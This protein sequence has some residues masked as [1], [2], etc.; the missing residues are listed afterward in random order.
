MKAEALESKRAI[1]SGRERWLR[2]IECAVAFVCL[3]ACATSSEFYVVSSTVQ[4]T[5]P[6]TQDEVVSPIARPAKSAPSV[7][8]ATKVEAASRDGAPSDDACEVRMFLE[9][10]PGRGVSDGEI[11]A[12]IAEQV[13]DG[14]LINGHCI[15]RPGQSLQ[16]PAAML[17]AAP[18]GRPTLERFCRSD[19]DEKDYQFALSVLADEKAEGSQKSSAA[20]RPVK[21]C[22][23]NGIFH[24]A[25]PFTLTLL[26]KKGQS[27]GQYVD[28]LRVYRNGDLVGAWNR[29]SDRET[30]SK[31]ALSGDSL[32]AGIFA[33][34]Q[35]PHL[36]DMDIRVI[37]R[38][39][40][41][42][43]EVDTAVVDAHARFRARLSV[44]V[45]AVRG[46]VLSPS[47][48]QSLE[49]LRESLRL[50]VRRIERVVSDQVVVPSDAPCDTLTKGQPELQALSTEYRDAKK[51]GLADLEKLRAEAYARIDELKRIVIEKLPEQQQLL[52]EKMLVMAFH[53]TKESLND[54]QR[55]AVVACKAELVDRDPRANCGKAILEASPTLEGEYG[56]LTGV[57]RVI[58]GDLTFL[59]QTVDEAM[60]LADRL[61]DK[62]K[63]IGSDPNRQAQVFNAFAQSLA[64]QG[65]VFEPRRDNPPLLVGEQKL[66]LKYADKFQFFTL[67]PWNGVPIRV[68]GSTGADFT[69]AIAIPLVDILGGRYQWGVSRFAELRG[70]FGLGYVQTEEPNSD[71]KRSA[72]LPNLSLGVGTFRVGV[73]VAVGKGFGSTGERVRLIAGV[74]LFKLLS[75]SNV[76]A[77]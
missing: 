51:K 26:A 68:K 71:S 19:E 67:A 66:D 62:V 59:T 23:W 53:S 8:G 34:T 35:P 70:A 57:L 77:L 27:L 43:Q 20:T 61:A 36:S 38:S 18:E 21:A 24:S 22:T 47:E 54:A 30:I 64:A 39:D 4:L 25:R 11:G 12:V 73:G 48:S 16:L 14:S 1:G 50:S 2:G 41:I 5:R 72:A 9:Q 7:N 44:A 37:P 46:L 29:A 17:I 60:A 49:C 10:L 42:R 65:D 74:D 55:A 15:K 6:E 32:V 58:D 45:D 69:A 56:K 3:G 40:G 52:I 31:I 75:G 13:T 76:E 63:G 28:F 33:A